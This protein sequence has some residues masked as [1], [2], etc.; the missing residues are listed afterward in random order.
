M[1]VSKTNRVQVDIVQQHYTRLDHLFPEITI[2]YQHNSEFCCQ[3]IINQFITMA[4][5][6]LSC[7][8]KYCN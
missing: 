6:G 8:E 7:V 2:L 1:R 5:V 3:V 4:C